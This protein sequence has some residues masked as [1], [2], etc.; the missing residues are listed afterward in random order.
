MKTVV[1][2]LVLISC[3]GV[4]FG[5]QNEDNEILRIGWNIHGDPSEQTLNQIDP[6]AAIFERDVAILGDLFEPLVHSTG[7]GIVAG[8]AKSWRHEDGGKRLVFEIDE[9]KKWS[10]G[11]SVTAEDF[12]YSLSRLKLPE[13]RPSLLSLLEGS[14]VGLN[15]ESTVMGVEAIDKNT[16]AISFSAPY[17]L[18]VAVFAH[19]QLFPL[20]QHVAKSL[21][22]PEL[23]WAQWPEPVS[24]G[25]YRIDKIAGNQVKLVLNPYY[26]TTDSTGL[27][28]R[29]EHFCHNWP[30]L[31]RQYLSGSLDV[32]NDVPNAQLVWIN[33]NALPYHSG[34]KFNSALVVNADNPPFDN[35]SVRGAVN[36][37]IDRLKL[38]S[39]LGA[40]FQSPSYTVV[41]AG[42][43]GYPDKS[44][45]SSQDESVSEARLLM[46]K[47]GYNSENR[48]DVKLLV[49]ESD[50][51]RLL[52]NG[53]TVQM[54]KIYIDIIPDYVSE[55]GMQLERLTNSD[56]EL[57]KI[58]WAP[59]Y[60]SPGSYLSICAGESP[61]IFCGNFV[62]TEF[63]NMVQ[64]A[65][66]LPG[67][68]SR[69]E[70]FR[71]AED[72]LLASHRILPLLTGIRP[73][74]IKDKLDVTRLDEGQR[75]RSV[76]I[77]HSY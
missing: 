72:I 16:L 46:E 34:S 29:V 6:S 9:N 64:Q 59:D 3:V 71:K 69:N 37:A 26:E 15:D 57:T 76:S 73:V 24:N 42:F 61:A 77:R 19:P 62:D 18:P 74:L 22:K 28:K 21:S 47:A 70:V 75:A 5:I 53:L 36:L 8:V 31:A 52:V 45:V 11:R 27:F 55:V 54:A 33:D 2:A 38:S 25:P 44:P 43:Q 66:Q 51:N 23:R 1:F 35:D 10:D 20:P 40:G 60:Y 14:I 41:P 56:Y 7:T 50:Y 65:E 30:E 63:N 32:I 49:V 12:V 4:S 68:A 39:A 67:T 13:F 58:S 17:V 48:L